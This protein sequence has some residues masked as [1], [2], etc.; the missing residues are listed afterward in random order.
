MGPE[1]ILADFA[2]KTNT[3][4]ECVSSEPPTACLTTKRQPVSHALAY[5]YMGVVSAAKWNHPPVL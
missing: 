4:G 1:V 2:C 5:S 3:G